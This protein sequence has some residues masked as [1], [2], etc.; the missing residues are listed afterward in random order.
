MIYSILSSAV[1]LIAHSLHD[2]LGHNHISSKVCA[3]NSAW[4]VNLLP[5]ILTQSENSSRKTIHQIVMLVST[6]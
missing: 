1:L 4:L 2:I 6:S 3:T 5:F